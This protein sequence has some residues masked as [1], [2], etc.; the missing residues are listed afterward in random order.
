[1]STLRSVA[2]PSNV[3]RGLR[4]S[5]MALLP[6]IAVYLLITA[7]PMLFPVNVVEASAPADCDLQHGACKAHFDNG[8]SIELAMQPLPTDPRQPMNARVVVKGL[9]AD[10]VSIVFDGI[11]MNMGRLEQ[12]LERDRDHRSSER[13]GGEVTLPVCIRGSM[14]WRATVQVASGRSRFVASFRLSSSHP[15]APRRA[16]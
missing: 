13:F 12:V 10:S 1:M 9:S 5:A 2:V 16:S 8:G 6:G 14:L 4:L 15:L 7:W 3:G 11:D